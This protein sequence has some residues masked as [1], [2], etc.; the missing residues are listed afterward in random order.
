MWAAWRPTTTTAAT[1]RPCCWS[2]APVRSLDLPKVSV[3]G[4]SFGGALILRLAAKAPE[5]VDRLILMGS[6]GVPFDLTPGLDAVW[7]FEPSLEAMRDLME[8]FTYDTS[9]VGED[10]PRL[11]LATAT[12]PGVHEAYA[13]MFPAP[14]ED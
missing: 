7:G 11:R 13:T 14:R 1:A 10:L 8:A 3:V 4:N 5:R 2:T 12:R 6:V 9:K